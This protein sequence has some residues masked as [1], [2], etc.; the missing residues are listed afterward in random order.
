MQLD[1]SQMRMAARYRV[2]KMSGLGKPLTAL[3]LACTVGFAV[4]DGPAAAAQERQERHDR[5]E[6][7]PRPLPAAE[8]AEAFIAQ[9]AEDMRVVSPS[10]I[11]R[12]ANPG[13]SVNEA[14]ARAELR[15]ALRHF[16]MSQQR[17]PAMATADRLLARAPD[18]PWARMAALYIAFAPALTGD[19]DE[20]RQAI[21][22]LSATLPEQDWRARATALELR[23]YIDRVQN[24]IGDAISNI[25][26]GVALLPDSREGRIYRKQLLFTLASVFAQA[27]NLPATLDLYQQAFTLAQA[28]DSWFDGEV[29]VNNLGY[30]L[31]EMRQEARAERAYR[32]LLQMAD[33]TG[34]ANRRFLAHAGLTW[35]LHELDRIEDSYKH[36]ETA[37]GL[38]GPVYFMVM[39]YQYQAINAARLGRLEEARA[40]LEQAEDRLARF[41]D[42]ID[43]I[44]LVRRFRARAAIARAEGRLEDALDFEARYTRDYVSAVQAALSDQL[45][46]SLLALQ[47][48]EGQRRAET[49]LLEREAA[50]AR[51][52]L[53][54][55]WLA[56][57]FLAIL[58]LVALG[59]LV[60]QRRS[61][62]ALQQSKLAAERAN[63]AKTAFL[64]NM[65][66]ELR[67]PLNALIGFSEMMERQMF[68]P[69][70]HQRYK[71]Y[72]SDMKAAAHHLLDLINDVLDLS[73]VESGRVDLQL[74]QVPL[75][76]AAA[77]AVKLVS[78]QFPGADKR[79][80]VSM[81][82]DIC[83][84]PADQ[85][86]LTRCLLNLLSNALKFSPPDSR[87]RL[88]AERHDDGG[89]SLGVSD[90][91]CGMTEEQ[92]EK[93]LTPFGQVQS[94]YARNHQGTGLGLPLVASYAAQHDARLEIRSDPGRG[95]DVLLHFPP[96][97]VVKADRDLAVSAA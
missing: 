81:P 29:A 73:R 28:T 61:A 47:A 80:D 52:R 67:T 64:A 77:E 36:G 26:S 48:V 24:R 62:T 42:L 41:P 18:G 5:V 72:A 91:G 40:Y 88:W 1:G 57:G 33:R 46:Q 27:R 68:G 31:N 3:A 71:D 95:T 86:I 44:E 55:Q 6:R 53:Q 75:Q 10:D 70:G 13:P 8:R 89:L 65:S 19:F 45:Q 59:G 4:S 78:G 85:R 35:S 94:V 83:L 21:D 66:H 63:A 69:L 11:A 32:T 79:I 58:V 97:R 2:G 82:A 51:E 34:S 76:P 22:S 14:A 20:A 43:G 25:R 7:L 56:L 87:V 92:I 37:I 90:Q 93:A 23:A 17:E 30:V 96:D 49:Q 15:H 38:G 12:A 50:L 54:G 16:T 39:L 74:D 9:L 60:W 84:G